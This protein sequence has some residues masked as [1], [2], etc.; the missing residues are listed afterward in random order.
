MLKS[1]TL[2]STLTFYDLRSFTNKTCLLTK[3]D[4]KK[5]KTIINS[6]KLMGLLRIRKG[7]K[8]YT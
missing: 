4:L 7:S 2:Y 6:L 3:K 1:T 8:M 5:K